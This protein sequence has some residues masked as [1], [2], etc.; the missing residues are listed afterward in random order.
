MFAALALIAVAQ[1]GPAPSQHVGD[2]Q[3]LSDPMRPVTEITRTSFTLQYFTVTPCETRIEL[4]AGDIPRTAY[5]AVWDQKV[6]IVK[7]ST[8][9]QTLHTLTLKNLRPGQ[10]YFYRIWDPGAKPTDQEKL[11]GA[12]D[13]WRREYAVSTQAPKGEKT[14][15]RIPVKV[16]LMPNVI[17]VESAYG[18]NGAAIAPNPEPISLADLNKVKEEFATS[19]RFFWVNSGMRLWVDYQ[20]FVDDRWQRW[21]PEPTKK[22]DKFY[23]GWPVCR[24]YPG[25]DFR[26]PGGG[27]FTI[28][29]TKN[30]QKVNKSPIVETKPY[31]GQIEVAFVRKWDGAKWQF[32]TSGGGTFGVDQ[33]PNGIPGRSQYLGGGDFAWLATHEFHHDLESHG[34]FSL[35]NREDERIVFNHPAPRFRK[36][37]NDGSADENA[38]N[39]AG[40]SGEHWQ[41]MWVW[42]RTLSDAQWLR[43]Y[44]GYTETVKDADGDGFP[45][46]DPRLP[47][48]EKRF[49]SNSQKPQS[50]GVTSDLQKVM[51]ST[52]APAPLQT[53][54]IKQ[55]AQTAIP[56]PTKPDSDG[57]GIPDISDPYPL[58]PYAPFIYPMHAA[59]DGDPSEWKDI[60]LAGKMNRGG[61][62]ATYQ[63]T[64][65]EASYYGLLTLKGPWRR[66]QAT[67]DGEGKGVYSN[68]GVQGFELTNRT[69]TGPAP[70]PNN[71]IVDI[72]PY[73]G[74]TKGLK[75]KAKKLA[76]DSIA[77]EFMWPNRGEGIW[78]WTGA[79]REIGSCFTIYD[80]DGRTS[81]IWE[82][83]QVFYSLMLE[84]HGKE[85][86]PNGAPKEIAPL[87]PVE[88][89]KPGSDR[90]KLG[91]KWKLEGDAYHC[92]GGDES[93][94]IV[95][96]PKSTEFD[97]FAIVEAKSD[98]VLAAFL[99][100]TKKT[101]A[102]SD[103]IGFVGGY[104]NT[105]TRLRLFGREV[106]D[107]AV[108]MTPGP[109]RLQLSRREGSIWLLVDNKPVLWAPD[110]NPKAMVDRLAILGGYDGRQVVREIRIKL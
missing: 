86:I 88:V 41:T 70:G 87:A 14:I 26:A 23:K 32:Y 75:W 77:I 12:S 69:S 83:Y 65:D 48:D 93:A 22:I 59:I 85:P 38:W 95:P 99:P 107:E 97:L 62:Q 33:F 3:P 44:F 13:G 96:I 47:L 94:L 9:K 92:D 82:P 64:H 19:A 35:S 72:R 80:N 79:G 57:D 31:S 45:D 90:V 46:S 16:L 49:G 2:L 60:P 106:G 1:I 5:K 55:A 110:P 102:G 7:G 74:Q 15:V 100:N 103:Y 67:F 91:G 4:R 54:W 52:W 50:D 42:D 11:W 53:T 101:D 18:D 56:N 89:I 17:N 27:E 21:G 66:V 25:E 108:V 78:F 24:S 36:V 68:E 8:G 10:R 39:T 51:L 6:A 104:G 61:I 40:R 71:S 81:S 30:I 76:D 109:H 43:M 84:A 29:D 58:I 28:V 105:T 98:G 63:Q 37:K 34:E 73:M 20:I